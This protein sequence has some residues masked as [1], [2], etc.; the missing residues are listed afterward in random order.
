MDAREREHTEASTHSQSPSGGHV[1]HATPIQS[2]CPYA[3]QSR[4][5]HMH[6]SSILTSNIT[7]TLL[8]LGEEAHDSLLRVWRLKKEAA[9]IAP[10]AMPRMP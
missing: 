7:E 9:T 8:L 1:T 4:H 2:S 3:Y 6:V 5:T 10:T